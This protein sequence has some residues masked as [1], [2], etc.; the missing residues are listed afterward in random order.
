MGFSCFLTDMGP[1]Y[2]DKRSNRMFVRGGVEGSHSPP[3]KKTKKACITKRRIN[4]QFPA[5]NYFSLVPFGTPAGACI[6]WTL[7]S[8]SSATSI[9]PCD[10][11]PA[12]LRG[13]KLVI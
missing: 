1:E 3:H 7:P 2:A 12:I 8:V 6:N 9:I 13:F 11:T 4:K 5:T 10:S